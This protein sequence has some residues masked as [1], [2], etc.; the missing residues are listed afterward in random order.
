MRICILIDKKGLLTVQRKMLPVSGRRK[1]DLVIV[2]DYYL[3]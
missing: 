3:D 2:N 1:F